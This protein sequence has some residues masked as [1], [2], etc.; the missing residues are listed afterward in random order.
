MLCLVLLCCSNR[1]IAWTITLCV[2]CASHTCTPAHMLTGSRRTLQDDLEV[3]D[4]KKAAAA[5]AEKVAG[6]LKKEVR[7]LQ[8]ALADNNIIIDKVRRITSRARTASSLTTCGS[9]APMAWQV[10][11]LL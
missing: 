3:L 2:Q 5:R 8:E 9:T 4:Q 7:L 10:P 11:S 1:L 6:Q